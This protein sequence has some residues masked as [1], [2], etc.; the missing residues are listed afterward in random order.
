[1]ASD[2]TWLKFEAINFALS[3]IYFSQNYGEI[4][5]SFPYS[6]SKDQPQ[7]MSCGL[8]RISSQSCYSLQIFSSSDNF[9]SVKGDYWLCTYSS[10][11]GHSKAN[12][13]FLILCL[14][15]PHLSPK[16]TVTPSLC[17]S[18]ASTASVLDIFLSFSLFLWFYCYLCTHTDMYRVN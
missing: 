3:F 16:V 1:M 10:F 11:H 8:R 4:I 6:L 7:F 12:P 14:F 13:S 5:H 2:S 18:A 9:T 15:Q 17:L